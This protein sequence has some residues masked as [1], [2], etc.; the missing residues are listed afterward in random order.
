MNIVLKKLLP[1]LRAQIVRW[2]KPTHAAAAAISY[3]LTGI[4]AAEAIR[5]KIESGEPFLASRIGTSELEALVTYVLSNLHSDY[6]GQ[7]VLQYLRGV[8]PKFWWHGGIIKCLENNAGMFST[9][10]DG[11]LQ[12]AGKVL[13]DCRS[14]DVLGSWNNDEKY[15]EKYLAKSIKIP[16]VDLEPYYNSPPWSMAL[17]NRKVLVIHPFESSIQEQYAIREELFKN[18]DT[19]PKFYLI[20]YQPI[21]NLAGNIDPRFTT[22]TEALEFMCK[23]ISGLDFDIAII[24]AGAYGLPLGAF[25]KK[26]GRQAIHLGGAT[27]ILFG[28][29]GARW[30]V[31]PFFRELFN[32][33]WIRPRAEETP[34]GASKVEGGCY[35]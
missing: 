30:E 9:A 32:E 34:A 22:W 35:W 12:F 5:R 7:K 14:V 2:N 10:G 19:L 8:I 21:Q 6:F 28:I 31:D 11:L 17:E 16:L 29:K 13:N 15:L 20:T 23:E 27:Q 33:K 4:A 18:K 26:M 24:G 1:R 25:I 3:D